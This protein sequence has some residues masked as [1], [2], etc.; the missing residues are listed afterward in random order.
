MI[1]K[2]LLPILLAICVVAAAITTDYTVAY[3]TDAS[4]SITNT[5][6]VDYDDQQDKKSGAVAR[7]VNFLRYIEGD[8]GKLEQGLRDIYHYTPII[9]KMTGPTDLRLYPQ[10]LKN[11]DER[12]LFNTQRCPK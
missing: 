4:G 1:K 12:N 9:K 3:Y 10:I 6:K 8:D 5:F 11:V 2:Y 7:C